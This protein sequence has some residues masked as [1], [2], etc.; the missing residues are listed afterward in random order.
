M[1]STDKPP[2]TTRAGH[3]ALVGRPNVGKST[4]LNLVGCIDIPDAGDVRVDGRPVASKKRVA[5]IFRLEEAS[6]T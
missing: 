2:T 4:L 3:V 1:T 5:V 6:G